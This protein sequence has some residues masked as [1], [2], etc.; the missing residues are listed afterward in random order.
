MI[1]ARPRRVKA[2]PSPDRPEPEFPPEG[3]RTEAMIRARPALDPGKVHCRTPTGGHQGGPRPHLVPGARL[4][5]PGG[6]PRPRPARRERE[7]TRIFRKEPPS[8]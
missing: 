6:P 1:A 4:A 5:R 2:R 3:P 7:D 8:T